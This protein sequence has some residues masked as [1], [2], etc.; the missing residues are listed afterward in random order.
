MLGSQALN[1][2]RPRP[3]GSRTS[4]SNSTQARK[5]QVN[6]TIQPTQDVDNGFTTPNK[7][8]YPSNKP[9]SPLVSAAKMLSLKLD[10][11]VDGSDS[12][13]AH[14]LDREWIGGKSRE[15][16]ELM[17]LNADKVIRDRDRDLSLAASIGQSLLEHNLVLRQRQEA[18]EARVSAATPP[19][20]ARAS[21][22]AHPSRQSRTSVSTDSPISPSPSGS[23][24]VENTALRP[25]ASSKAK[26]PAWNS[27][28][29]STASTASTPTTGHSPS[30]SIRSKLSISI[31]SRELNEDSFHPSSASGAQSPAASE[32]SSYARSRA[33]S[34]TNP[35]SPTASKMNTFAF[36]LSPERHSAANNSMIASLSKQNQELSAKLAELEQDAKEVDVAGKKRLRKLEKELGALKGELDEALKRNEELEEKGKRTPVPPPVV[37]MPTTNDDDVFIPDSSESAPEESTPETLST[38][39]EADETIV[40][41]QP[42]N[43][44]DLLKV[45][46]TLR[47]SKD[48]SASSDT[49]NVTSSSSRS[50]IIDLTNEP[51]ERALVAELMSKIAELEEANQSIAAEKSAMDDRL[52]DAKAAMER[53]RQQYEEAEEESN[54]LEWGGRRGL[55]GWKKSKENLR[56]GKRKGNRGMIER[57]RAKNSLMIEASANQLLAVDGMSGTITPSA[58]NFSIA[59]SSSAAV[60]QFSPTKV[61]SRH[62]STDSS[63]SR[64]NAF[65]KEELET[66]RNKRKRRER[67]RSD[68]SSV[69]Q[70]KIRSL[71][72][73][74]GIVWDSHDAERPPSR[75]QIEDFG[76]VPMQIMETGLSDGWEDLDDGEET[77]R[78]KVDR[79]HGLVNDYFDASDSKLSSSFESTL[80][81]PNATAFPTF[82]SPARRATNH[83]MPPTISKRSAALRRLGFH[84]ESSNDEDLDGYDYISKIDYDNRKYGARGTDYY[85]TA[86]R[87]RYAPKMVKKRVEVASSRYVDLMV[88][89][90]KSSSLLSF[91]QFIKDQT[92]LSGLSIEPNDT[93]IRHSRTHAVIRVSHGIIHILTIGISIP[94]PSFWAFTLESNSS[95][96]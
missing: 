8:P 71:G 18:L 79:E 51:H 30:N 78:E 85:P 38:A 36:P 60:S 41:E 72:S 34:S 52:E 80:H 45:D 16:L 70:A 44:D 10:N 83:D 5:S 28:A 27:G 87:A 29:G 86:V 20:R 17:L 15:E 7:K 76:L 1:T 39:S 94:A 40:V 61:R 31:S 90:T 42:L 93:S 23:V 49:T 46:E 68:L 57:R 75:L 84:G 4:S 3:P 50:S 82:P 77:D 26:R 21:H 43:A 67:T 37:S 14:R 73:E 64:D 63:F 91:M 59:S 92:R 53:L 11:D 24:S 25:R 47:H 81:T 9:E 96:W 33:S 32:R 2:P 54:M 66:Y 22:P 6:L 88:T 56:G 19:V 13:G 89:W 69:S 12:E 35:P 74:L 95:S 62:R 58:S 65:T 55:I 48:I